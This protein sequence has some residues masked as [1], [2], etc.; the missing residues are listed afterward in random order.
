[1]SNEDYTKPAFDPSSGENNW[2]SKKT[3]TTQETNMNFSFPALTNPFTKIKDYFNPKKETSEPKETTVSPTT[4][5][6]TPTV[7]T[8]TSN[9]MMTVVPPGTKKVTVKIKEPNGRLINEYEISRFISLLP[10]QKL[11][12]IFE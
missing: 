7:A 1:M 9:K 6:N 8:Q 5:L 10:G 3:N 11:E 2:A 12:V 4:Q